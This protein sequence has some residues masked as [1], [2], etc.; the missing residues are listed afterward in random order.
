MSPIQTW[1][2]EMR[3]IWLDKRPDD[4]ASI[5]AEPLEY[6]ETPFDPPLTSIDAVVKEWQA[7]KTQDIELIDIELLHANDKIGMAQWKFKQRNNPLHIGAYYIELND[8]G[9]CVHFRQW[10]NG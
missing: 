3:S 1:L 6:Y 9:K 8:E 4:M 5:L 10:W 7:I 2:N